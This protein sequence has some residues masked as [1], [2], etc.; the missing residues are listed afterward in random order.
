MMSKRPKFQLDD[1]V[2]W[3]HNAQIIEDKILSV[4]RLDDDYVTDWFG[5][6][7]KSMG[8]GY[9]Y[10]NEDDLYTSEEEARAAIPFKSRL[11]SSS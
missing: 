11:S 3:V 9:D 7:M 6:Q 4:T 1:I 8:P 5:Y 2:Y 10:Q